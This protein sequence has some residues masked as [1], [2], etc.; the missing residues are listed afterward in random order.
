MIKA[1][2]K[3]WA[4]FFFDIYLNNIIKKDFKD[5]YLVGNIPEL[6]NNKGLIITPNHFSWWDGFFIYY[7]MKKLSTRKIYIMMLEEQLKRYPF[8]KKLGAFSINQ[9]SP[10]SII[11]SINYASSIV[12]DSS[13]FVTYPQ[14]EI[15]P[16]EKRPL[17][18]K[19]GLKKITEKVN[20]ETDVLPVAFK[21]HHSN[22]R[23]PFLFAMMG[24]MIPAQTVMDNFQ[25]FS[26]SYNQLVAK[27]D[28]K[29]QNTEKV[30]LFDK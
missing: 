4:Y 3:K 27:L 1:E 18:V 21:I 15:E 5:F 26:D 14:G 29:Y 28:A 10:K 20:I 11:E 12:S 22:E 7:L 2:H 6:D 9:Q 17:T 24:N 13:Y 25:S 16:Y 19:E 23:K 30:S 8:F